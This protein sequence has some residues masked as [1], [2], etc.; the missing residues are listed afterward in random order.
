MNIEDFMK[1]TNGSAYEKSEPRYGV[2]L[3][4]V[5]EKIRYALECSHSLLQEIEMCIPD[6]LPLPDGYRE[7]APFSAKQDLLKSPAWHSFDYQLRAFAGLYNML[8]SV[9]SSA[10]VERLG[11]MSKDDFKRWLD[12]IEHEGSVLGLGEIS[13]I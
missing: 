5:G 12:Y 4:Y 2:P 1:N 3:D 8:A 7:G 10:D 9:D 11:K 13:S 6:D